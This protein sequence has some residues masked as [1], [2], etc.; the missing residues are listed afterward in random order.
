[1]KLAAILQ[2]AAE[3]GVRQLRVRVTAMQQQQQQL[4]GWSCRQAALL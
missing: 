2:A 3:A 4:R 1:M